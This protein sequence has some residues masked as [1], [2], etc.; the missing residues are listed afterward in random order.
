[1]AR[2]RL[3]CNYKKGG[4]TASYQE[5]KNAILHC[6]NMRKIASLDTIMNTRRSRPIVIK[7]QAKIKNWLVLT[8]KKEKRQMSESTVFQ[9]HLPDLALLLENSLCLLAQEL[10]SADFIDDVFYNHITRRDL[11][12]PEQERNMNMIFS[13]YDKMKNQPATAEK[14]MKNFLSILQKEVAWRSV[15]SDIGKSVLTIHP[16]NLI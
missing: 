15:Y 14:L 7:W 16:H 1:M 10:W 11:A 9:E 6:T 12:M 2:P 3:I 5:H 4:A 8:K 13:I